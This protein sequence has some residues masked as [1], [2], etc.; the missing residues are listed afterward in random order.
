M[1][2]NTPSGTL[3]AALAYQKRGLPVFPV[4]P[5]LKVPPRGFHW[6]DEAA[7]DP[8]RAR[9]WF[10]NGAR[11]NIGLAFLESGFFAIDLDQKK[12]VDGRKALV[13]L[14]DACGR[15]L[16]RTLVHGTPH[17]LHLIYHY[18][19]A[20]IKSA[21]SVIAPGVDVKGCD[22]YILAPPSGVGGKRYHVKKHSGKEIL[23][24]PEWLVDL[25]F[26]ERATRPVQPNTGAPAD[27]LEG[28]NAAIKARGARE[29]RGFW[30]IRCINPGHE[31]LHP[32]AY[33]HPDKGFG[34]CS[35]CESK[36]LT[37]DAARI[38]NV[39]AGVPA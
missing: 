28:V 27:L 39:S 6:K 25:C 19:G 36:W 26:G 37:V 12:G 11:F 8:D 7:L 32:S 14:I 5:G 13:D 2:D 15:K 9:K 33:W 34:G 21:A 17:G 24:A 38:L 30:S 16:P 1:Q 35:A 3:E 29:G 4:A 18:D 22:G 20:L 23:D 10:S 31:D